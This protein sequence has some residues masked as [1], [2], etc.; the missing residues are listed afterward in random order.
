MYLCSN[1]VRTRAARVISVMRLGLTV[2]CRRTVQRWVSRANPRSPRQRRSRSSAFRVRA[3]VSSSGFP[4]GSS[5]GRRSRLPGSR[6]G[7]RGQSARGDPIEEGQGA[8]VGGG[9]R[10]HAE[11]PRPRTDPV[12]THAFSRIES[13]L[14]HSRSH[15]FERLHAPIR[16]AAVTVM[17]TNLHPGLSTPEAVDA[18]RRAVQIPAAKL[19]LLAFRAGLDELHRQA[20][21]IITEC[22]LPPLQRV[23]LC[24]KCGQCR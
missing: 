10:R 6:C 20:F 11:V 9:Q 21:V 3:P 13:A 14:T 2:T 18:A 5:P 8:P 19:L 12:L 24:A 4:A 22:A 7:Q 1:W 16:A 23:S 17:T 15:L